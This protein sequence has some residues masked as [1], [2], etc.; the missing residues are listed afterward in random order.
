METISEK[1]IGP[2]WRENY[3]QRNQSAQCN[4]VCRTLAVLI[5]DRANFFTP[6]GDFD[7][8]LKL[9]LDR[10]EIPLVEFETIEKEESIK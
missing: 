4:S 5:R 7:T 9:V 8:R 2:L 6:A 1:D 10:L 3:P